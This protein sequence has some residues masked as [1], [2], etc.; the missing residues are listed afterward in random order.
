MALVA[1]GAMLVANLG[2]NAAP[3]A[4][5]VIGPMAMGIPLAA[6]TLRL[7]SPRVRSAD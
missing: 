3:D 5:V 1:Y 7:L 2:V 4:L 6:A